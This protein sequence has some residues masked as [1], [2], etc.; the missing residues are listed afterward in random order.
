M[1]PAQLLNDFKSSLSKRLGRLMS[2][3]LCMDASMHMLMI[4]AKMYAGLLNGEQTDVNNAK[5]RPSCAE[6]K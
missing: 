6:G 1:D 5:E 4:V 3:K 2:N